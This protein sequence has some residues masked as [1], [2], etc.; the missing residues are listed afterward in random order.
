MTRLTNRPRFPGGNA[1][2][3][4]PGSAGYG[5]LWSDANIPAAELVWLKADLAAT[6]LPTIV[7]THQLLNPEEQVD[8]TFDP[9]HSIKNAGDVRSIL[10]KSGLVMAA[11]AGHYHDGGYQQV[12][13]IHYITLQASAAYGNDASYHNQ[14]ATVDVYQDGRK[15]QIAIAGNGGARSYVL[16]STLP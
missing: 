5:Y 9:A 4:L 15:F 6:K 16:S 12:N 2:S 10:E 3:G 14:Y 8:A 7:F 11:I 1:Y 13:S